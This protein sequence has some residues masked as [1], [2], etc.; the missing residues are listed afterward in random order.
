MPSAL[1]LRPVCFAAILIAFKYLLSVFKTMDKRS[2]ISALFD[3]AT[4]R[5]YLE[6]L[7]KRTK[8]KLLIFNFL[9]G[10]L[11]RSR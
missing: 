2:R 1:G 5:R 7:R 9:G 3:S 6:M 8:F 11:D 4:R 10:W